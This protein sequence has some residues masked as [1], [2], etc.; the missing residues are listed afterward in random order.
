M[1]AKFGGHG[2]PGFEDFALFC[3]PSKRPKF[4]FESWTIVHGGQKIE[5][6]LWQ[7][8]LCRCTLNFIGSVY[9]YIHIYIYI[10]KLA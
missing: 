6:K 10:Y 8:T 1:E 3:L 9:I 7:Q 5:S 2:L 4:P